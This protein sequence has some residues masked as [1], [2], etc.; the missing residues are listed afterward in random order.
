MTT[1][2]TS[3]QDEIFSCQST[4]LIE[5]TSPLHVWDIRQ[6]MLD[7]S[8]GTFKPLER[9]RTLLISLKFKVQGI[10]GEKRYS[11]FLG[12]HRKTPTAT[13]SLQPGEL[14]E[15]KTKGEILATLDSGGRN[16]GL[17]FTPEMLKY[18]GG[19]YRVLKRLNAMINE[20]T[21]KMRQ[22]ANTVI[23][24]KVTCDGK[25]HGGC[26]R[27]CYCFWREIWLKRVE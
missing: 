11:L 20:R 24:E 27:T 25:A 14:V 15:V 10:V 1:N 17:E 18:C 16:R 8:S 4:N 2:S 9:I 5:A 13:L 6:Y 26:Q 3:S 7:V 19:K 21:R 22:I 23:L 12:K